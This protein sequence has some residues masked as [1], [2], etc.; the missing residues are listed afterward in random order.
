MNTPEIR[1]S[2]RPCYSQTE[3]KTYLKCGKMWEFRYARGIKTPP[4]AP[5][6][7]GSAVD[8]AVHTNLAQKIV[9]GKDLAVEAVLDEFSADFDR[10]QLETEWGDS[11][12]GEQKDMG[13]GLVALHHQMAAPNIQPATVQET[14][15]LETDA[16]YD[17][18]GVMDLT[19]K[20]GVVV[21][22]KTSRAPYPSNALERSFQPA[23]YDF[24]FERTRGKPAEGFRFDVLVKNGARKPPQFQRVEGK[25]SL[26]DREWFFENV[27]RIH[28]AI[29]HGVALP[30]PEGSWYCSSKWCGYWSQCKGRSA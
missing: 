23:L 30:A 8:T 13:A 24:A 3:L 2:A 26:L 20:S 25:I 6:T 18:E 22:T 7:L 9:T 11:D 14:F 16:G 28:K 27:S 29:S 12:P 19:E 1:A 10:R 15:V 17:L 4:S 5:L 21:D